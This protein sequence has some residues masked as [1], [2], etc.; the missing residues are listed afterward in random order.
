MRSVRSFA[1]V[2]GLLGVCLGAVASPASAAV[3]LPDPA[4]QARKVCGSGYHLLERHTFIEN[5]AA[6]AT[7]FLTYN[8]ARST[9]CVVTLRQ[10]ATPQYG[11]RAYMGSYVEPVGSVLVRNAGYFRSYAGP[12]RAHLADGCVRWG[13]QYRSQTWNGQT[14]AKPEAKMSCPATH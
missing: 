13:G 3:P 2:L 5:R 4:A 6:A 8:K 7:T 12:T 11:D 1:A 14:P 9:A 10:S